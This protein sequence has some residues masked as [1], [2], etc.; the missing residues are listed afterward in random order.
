MTIYDKP[1]INI[2]LRIKFC[3]WIVLAAFSILVIRL[4]YLQIF[5]G[6]YFRNLS[7]NN[8]MR[9][10]YIEAPRG[11]IYDRTGARLA[12][13]RPSFNVELV[14]EDCPDEKSTI[15]RLEK[16]LGMEEGFISRQNHDLNKR[17]KPFE[18]KILLRDVSRN[19]V[20]KILSRRF[21]L[22]GIIVSSVPTR[23]YIH[24]KLAAHLLGYIREI[25]RVQLSKP[26]YKEY[27]AG[28]FVGQS[29]VEG[30]YEKILRG[31]R[32][33]QRIEV[34]AVGARISEFE[35][36]PERM[37]NDIYLTI[38]HRLQKAAEEALAGK[39]GAVVALEPFTGEVLTMA[40]APSFNPNL[41][42]AQISPNQWKK[43]TDK[44]QLRLTNRAIQG[45]YPPGSVFKLVMAAAALMEG[46]V[47]PNEK[48][49][50]GGYISFADRRYHCH[51]RSGHGDID[52]YSAIVQ[53]CDVYFYNLGQRLGIDRINQYARD[54]GLG[55]LTGIDLAGEVRG[56]VP[57][58][59]WKRHAFKEKERQIW[60][61]GETLSVSIGQ[62]ALTVTP[63]QVAVAVSALVN[64]GWVM[65]P[66]VVKKIVSSDKE[67]IDVFKPIRIR[68]V[69]VSEGVLEIINK[70]MIG[71]VNDAKGTGHRAQLEGFSVVVGGK[72]GTAQVV[73]LDNHGKEQHLNDH[74]WFAGFAPVEKPEIVVVALIENGGHGGVAAAPVVKKVMEAFFAGR[75][76]QMMAKVAS[77]GESRM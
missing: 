49:H 58:P 75:Q 16:I 53:S 9:T 22:P 69:H 72:T 37:G 29:G 44:S 48:I 12:A 10:V 28:D 57:S 76:K 17:R 26:A 14:T 51:K 40:S 52:L 19:T 20:A 25:S 11:I 36:E 67:E 56:L 13:N 55:S 70:A 38:D 62:G 18:P 27:R 63:L 50:C 73:S 68:K 77:V 30:R 2:S 5:K 21:L 39:K 74:A 71:V 46:V 7:E 15:R 66:F 33:L 60:Y 32:G 41:F 65:K 54:F 59:Q 42:T 8:R 35:F 3:R 1:T 43:L 24:G 23:Q 47:K 64:G 31:V 45:A 34:N 61:P 4:W 6:D